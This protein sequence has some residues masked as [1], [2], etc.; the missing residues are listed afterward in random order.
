MAK[1]KPP[2]VEHRCE[3]RVPE[4]DGWG[5]S[6][7]CP[8]RGKFE[9]NGKWYCGIHD[10]VRKAEKEK[11]RDLEYN[12]E[13]KRRGWNIGRQDRFKTAM[14]N[15]LSLLENEKRIDARLALARALETD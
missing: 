6:R 2:K 4:P 9:R 5:R 10:P 13:S 11:Q 7:S 12:A 14:K 8:N 3:A 1:Q 15:A